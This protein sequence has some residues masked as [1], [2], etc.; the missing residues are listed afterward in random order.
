MPSC[1]KRIPSGMTHNTGG[2]LRIRSRYL[3]RKRMMQ[4]TTH[5]MMNGIKTGS[6]FQNGGEKEGYRH[7]SDPAGK[8][9]LGYR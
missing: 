4:A 5:R 7:E 9:D 8:T 6:V 2:R 3:N 1:L